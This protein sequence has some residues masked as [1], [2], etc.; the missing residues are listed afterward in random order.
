MTSREERGAR[1]A[2]KPVVIARRSVVSKP[3]PVPTS[4]TDH[5]QLTCMKH[6]SRQLG[7]KV[8][9]LDRLNLDMLRAVRGN[10]KRAHEW[11][12]LL[13]LTGGFLAAI[14]VP[15][16]ARITPHDAVYSVKWKLPSKQEGKSYPITT[17]A[18][19][20]KGNAE[21]FQRDQLLVEHAPEIADGSLGAHVFHFFDANDA[22][23]FQFLLCGE[24]S[25][26]GE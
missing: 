20:S 19:R 18:V 24:I 6:N 14:V 4:L 22:F 3:I 10:T 9:P 23:I 21:T 13:M 25:R 26:R 11:G 1:S 2:F 8:I 7:F 15:D 12:S 5:A 17:V 16:L